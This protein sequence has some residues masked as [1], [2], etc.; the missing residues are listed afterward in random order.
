MSKNIMIKAGND[1]IECKNVVVILKK[2]PTSE[3]WSYENEF[4][5]KQY[6]HIRTMWKDDSGE[7]N[8]GKGVSVLSADAPKMLHALK[9]LPQLKIVKG[10]KAKKAA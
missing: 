7:W 5:G 6:F 9:G 10:A 3:V 2:T 8:M 4:R 1:T